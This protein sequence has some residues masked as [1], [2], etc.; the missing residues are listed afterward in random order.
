MNVRSSSSWKVRLA[1]G[2]AVAILLALGAF[3]YR[4]VFVASESDRWVLHTELVLRSLEELRVEMVG[5]QSSIRGFIL[6]GKETYFEAYRA[7]TLRTARNAAAGRDLT[8]DN[9]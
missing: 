6:T 4:S 1:F 7:A 5:I 9:A 3:S 2:A 8:A